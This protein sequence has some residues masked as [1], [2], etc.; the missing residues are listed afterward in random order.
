MSRKFTAKGESSPRSSLVRQR[1]VETTKTC[2]GYSRRGYRQWYQEM[3]AVFD[4]L[5]RVDEAPA[6]R[7]DGRAI[8][9]GWRCRVERGRK[10]SR[11]RAVEEH[12][13]A[14]LKQ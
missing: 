11:S 3:V 9:A 14:L 6:S 10:M 7:V 8:V 1:R 5:S 2:Q 13:N 4:E 12:R